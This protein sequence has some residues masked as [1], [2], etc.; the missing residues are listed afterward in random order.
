MKK[1][2]ERVILATGTITFLVI[3]ILSALAMGLETGASSWPVG[4]VVVIAMAGFS[5]CCS[6][7][8]EHTY[9]ASA[10]ETTASCSK[11]MNGR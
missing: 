7:Y 2:E 9:E 10:A 1:L 3:C 6:T 11:Q 4:A 5:L 8:V